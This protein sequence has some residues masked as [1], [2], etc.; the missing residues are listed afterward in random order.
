MECP[1]LGSGPLGPGAPSAKG[2]ALPPLVGT[3]RQVTCPRPCRLAFA[4][5]RVLLTTD[6]VSRTDVAV[7]MGPMG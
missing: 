7:G 6:G 4:L 2:L 1:S 3:E 5:S